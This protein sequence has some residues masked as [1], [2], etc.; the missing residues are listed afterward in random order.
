MHHKL[1]E[2]YSGT[3]GVRYIVTASTIA[4]KVDAEFRIKN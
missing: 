2:N 3:N 4:F 1:T